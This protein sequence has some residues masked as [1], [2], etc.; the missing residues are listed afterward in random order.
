MLEGDGPADLGVTAE[1]C[2][3]VGDWWLA[4][5]L[6]RMSGVSEWGWRGQNGIWRNEREG[7]G[8]VERIEEVEIEGGRGVLMVLRVWERAS[9]VDSRSGSNLPN[10]WREVDGRLSGQSLPA[11]TIMTIGFL[12]GFL[13]KLL[14]WSDG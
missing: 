7:L 10:A 13:M 8:D 9:T 3:C 5:V 14:T 6:R 1:D 4:G 11:L 2:D 12:W